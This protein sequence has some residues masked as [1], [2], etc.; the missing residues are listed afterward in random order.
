MNL[1]INLTLQLRT[2]NKPSMSF[3]RNVWLTEKC[4]SVKIDI[5]NIL[6]TDS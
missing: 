4:L 1:K 2:V 6:S 5:Y 3:L